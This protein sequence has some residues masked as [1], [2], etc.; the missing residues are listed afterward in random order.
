MLTRWNHIH[1]YDCSFYI[2]RGAGDLLKLRYNSRECHFSISDETTNDIRGTIL[3][4]QTQGPAYLA[5]LGHIYIFRATGSFMNSAMCHFNPFFNQTDRSHLSAIPHRLITRS[6]YDHSFCLINLDHLDGDVYRSASAGDKRR[7]VLQ[8]VGR[9]NK[10]GVRETARTTI[11]P[12]HL[13]SCD[14]R[15]YVSLVRAT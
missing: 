4:N 11:E 2:W 3:I 15:D 14:I 5:L 8:H 13:N 7:R 9:R 1:T 12:V 10:D 6:L